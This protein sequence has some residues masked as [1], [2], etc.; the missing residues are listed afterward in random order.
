MT[1]AKKVVKARLL[2]RD[3]KYFVGENTCRAPQETCPRAPGAGY[4]QCLT[5]CKQPMHAEMAALFAA[6]D[7]GSEPRG[8]HM[9]IWHHRCCEEC[10]RLLDRYQITWELKA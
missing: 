8:G 6:E 5:V 2:C 7:G 4:L 9:V 10:Q 3:G 1:C